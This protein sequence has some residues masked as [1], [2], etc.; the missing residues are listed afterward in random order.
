MSSWVEH[1]KS[2]ITSGPGSLI[3]GGNC[4]LNFFINLPNYMFQYSKERSQWDDSFE[5]QEHM[6]RLMGK[7]I[8]VILRTISLLIWISL[9]Y[10]ARLNSPW[11]PC[12]SKKKLT[13]SPWL[14]GAQS[15]CLQILVY[16]FKK[17]P[18]L[19]RSKSPWLHSILEFHVYN[20]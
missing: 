1:E 9:L 11:I 13:K 6:F 16:D 20:N 2:F 15:P 5:Y 10:S 4:Q 14:C 19:H 17:T 3:K 7:K 18:W 12:A 8:R